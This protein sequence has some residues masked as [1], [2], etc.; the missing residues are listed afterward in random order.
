MLI[1]AFHHQEDEQLFHTCL[2]CCVL[3]CVDKVGSAE[4][5]R[6]NRTYSSRSA[7]AYPSPTFTTLHSKETS[8]SHC[9]TTPKAS[10]SYKVVRHENPPH[11]HHHGVQ[12][13][14]ISMCMYTYHPNGSTITNSGTPTSNGLV[15]VNVAVSP[16][17]LAT[18]ALEYGQ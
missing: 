17:L 7:R 5:P 10:D 4:Y 11:Q 18:P 3:N 2:H 6:N 8:K 12:R 1:R 9:W 15:T 14:Y 16:G 13:K